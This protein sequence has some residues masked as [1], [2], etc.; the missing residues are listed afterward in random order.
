MI[1]FFFFFLNYLDKNILNILNTTY[2]NICMTL[3]NIIYNH[4]IF[5][6]IDFLKFLY[7]MYLI[8]SDYLY[9]DV[10]TVLAPPD[11]CLHW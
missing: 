5:Y 6:L 1:L 11:F 10:T 2:I 4:I 3:K 8:I 7:N 9:F